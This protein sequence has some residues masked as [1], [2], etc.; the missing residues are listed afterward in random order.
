MTKEQLEELANLVADKLWEKQMALETEAEQS[1][2]K[3]GEMAKLETML[4]IL[5]QSEE[6][7]KAYEVKQKLDKLKTELIE[8]GILRPSED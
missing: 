4:S 6:Y 8:A 3:I 2:E 7:A 5:E 1:T